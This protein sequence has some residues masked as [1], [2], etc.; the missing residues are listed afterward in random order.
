M[1]IH[2]RLKSGE[3][4]H[5]ALMAVFHSTRDGY[6]WLLLES[7]DNIV[8][9]VAATGIPFE[10][11]LPLFISQRLVRVEVTS[12]VRKYSVNRKMVDE[13]FSLRLMI[14]CK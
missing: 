3:E 9:I 8:E 2:Q 13:C 12:V 14:A 4:N 10:Y 5:H 1:V 7:L 11:T 6:W